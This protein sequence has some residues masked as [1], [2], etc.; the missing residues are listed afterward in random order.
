MPSFIADGYEF[1]SGISPLHNV[2]DGIEIFHRPMTP[3]ESSQYEFEYQRSRGDGEKARGVQAD[4]LMKKIVRW[5]LP[6]DKDG[7]RGQVPKL[8]KEI[9]T[10]GDGKNVVEQNLLSQMIEVVIWGGAPDYRIGD[11]NDQSDEEALGN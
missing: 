3:V 10:V 1:G 4:W 6:K 2:H 7:N 9:L 11:K 5:Q 8:S